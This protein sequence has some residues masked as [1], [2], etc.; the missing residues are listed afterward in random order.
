MAKGY[1]QQEDIDYLDTFSLVA[2]LVTVEVFLTLVAIHG[3]SLTQ[4]DVNNVFLHGD[5]MEKF[6]YC[7]LYYYEGESFPANVVCKLYKSLYGL[8]SKFSNALLTE[9]FKQ[10][11]ID[12][13]LFMKQ[14]GASFI[15]LLVYVDHI[16]IANNSSK[17]VEDL[18]GF[19]NNHFK[20]ND[21]GESEIFFRA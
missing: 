14:L 16:V 8:N 5:L 2:K 10:S 4:L 12:H 1:T 17:Y 19:L 9:G 18:K 13:S 7:Y 21:L 11:T 15:A 6:T 3:Q 20:L